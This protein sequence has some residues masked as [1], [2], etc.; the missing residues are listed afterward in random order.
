MN[1]QEFIGPYDKDRCHF[2]G[3]SAKNGVKHVAGFQRR[4][5]SAPNGPFYDCCQ[6]CLIKGDSK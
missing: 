6:D 3:K 1:E 5:E 2:C 4:E